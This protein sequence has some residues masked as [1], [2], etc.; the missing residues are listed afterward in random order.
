MCEAV[1]K[2][3]RDKFGEKSS[4][5]K[6]GVGDLYPAASSLPPPLC[7]SV[8]RLVIEI[9]IGLLFNCIP[10]GTHTRTNCQYIFLPLLTPSLFSG[11][12]HSTFDL[13]HFSSY[14]FGRRVPFPH[15]VAMFINVRC[16]V[17]GLGYINGGHATAEGH[18]AM[19]FAK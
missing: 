3:Q 4:F 19:K 17:F 10:N 9:Q 11:C 13:W 8:S 16:S 12:R 14:F 2:V 7:Y 18:F 5:I 15:F 1:H 6:S